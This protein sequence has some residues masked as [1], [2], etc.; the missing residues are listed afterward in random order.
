M[1]SISGD[2][3]SKMER[4]CECLYEGDKRTMMGSNRSH[5]TLLGWLKNATASNTPAK[6]DFSLFRM[7]PRVTCNS[8][9]Q[10]LCSVTLSWQNPAS[11]SLMKATEIKLALYKH[12][13][14]LEAI[15]T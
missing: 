13:I 1:L 10:I 7:P 3:L 12:V 4:L 14:L 5:G 15:N 2:R 6:L 9:T 11:D 8:M